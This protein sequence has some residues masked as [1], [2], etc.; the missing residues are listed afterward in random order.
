MLG[1][2]DELGDTVEVDVPPDIPDSADT[3]DTLNN[4]PEAV[5]DGGLVRTPL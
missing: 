1:V 5:E 3:Q 4:G 2:K